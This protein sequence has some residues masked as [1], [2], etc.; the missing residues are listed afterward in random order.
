M[1]SHW[2]TR[3][4]TAYRRGEAAKWVACLVAWKLLGTDD[5]SGYADELVISLAHARR[6]AG[7]YQTYRE[8]RTSTDATAARLFRHKLTIR[9]LMTFGEL[10][11]RYEFSPQAG[12]EYLL[13]AVRLKI[14]VDEWRKLIEGKEGEKPEAWRAELGKAV[15]QLDVVENSFQLPEPVRRLTKL[16]RGISAHALNGG[17]SSYD[18]YTIDLFEILQP[19]TKNPPD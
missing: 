6:M 13:D 12:I 17:L 5:L 4:L 1:S 2:Y 16:Y 8:L 19:K 9:H 11:R 7:A 10:Q 3:G 14:P 15:E 18:E